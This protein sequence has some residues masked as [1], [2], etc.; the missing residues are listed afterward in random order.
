MARHASRETWG[1]STALMMLL[2]LASC[3]PDQPRNGAGQPVD[4]N[5]GTIAPGAAVTE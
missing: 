3:A 2:L 4:R 1:L 5:T